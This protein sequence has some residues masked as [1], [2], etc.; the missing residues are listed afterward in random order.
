M[1]TTR[2]DGWLHL[3]GAASILPAELRAEVDLIVKEVD[4]C[5]DR[6]IALR[7]SHPLGLSSM[8]NLVAALAAADIGLEAA[9]TS[10]PRRP[11]PG[12][13]VSTE[14]MRSSVSIASGVA[15][16]WQPVLADVP[17]ALR[18]MPV[19]PAAAYLEKYDQAVADAVRDARKRA[20][21]HP[22]ARLLLNAVALAASC[23]LVVPESVAAR[24]PKPDADT[25]DSLSSALDHL[26][27]LVALSE[28][29]L[30]DEER[31]VLIH[32]G[33]LWGLRCT[34][35]ALG[36]DPGWLGTTL[37]ALLR[38]T[39]T[40]VGSERR[41]T[42]RLLAAIRRVHG[43][44]VLRHIRATEQAT[45]SWIA[46][47]EP[48]LRDAG[49]ADLDERLGWAALAREVSE[50]EA[51]LAMLETA[52]NATE[53]RLERALLHEQRGVLR[54]SPDE[55]VRARELL[56]SI[57]Q[58]QGLADPWFCLCY[59]RFLE[60]R[61]D[62]EAPRWYREITRTHHDNVFLMTAAAAAMLKEG[63]S[64]GAGA[65]VHR[66][67]QTHEGDP[68]AR[69]YLDHLRGELARRQLD[70]PTA[71]RAFRALLTQEEGHLPSLVS[72]GGLFLDIG[73]DAT[74]RYWLDRA[75][76]VDSENPQARLLSGMLLCRA[77]GGEEFAR[78]EVL[79]RDLI[80]ESPGQPEAH[81][82]LA[83]ALRRS[84]RTDEARR[85]LTDMLPSDR[86][87]PH[88]Q[89]ELAQVDLLEQNYDGAM[90]RLDR[91][92]RAGAGAVALAQQG[93][94]ACLRDGELR[95]DL[96]RVAVVAAATPISRIRIFNTWAECALHLN[97]ND[98]AAAAVTAAARIDRWNRFT[99]DLERQ[100]GLAARHQVS[101]QAFRETLLTFTEPPEEGGTP[102][103]RLES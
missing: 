43:R 14:I 57:R 47:L 80:Q 50:P 37:L 95:D 25:P 75:L 94:L 74:A 2:T 17:F 46:G 88:R 27:G 77:P 55:F 7:V 4:R 12:A 66:A 44:R 53:V 52:G 73:Y 70:H 96:F 68:Q 86:S 33:E 93:R 16:E 11:R 59:A 31:P 38:S 60:A 65:M 82:A 71:E 103:T 87:E 8:G 3:R 51:G 6:P 32:P 18:R 89:I 39:D 20:A 35:E 58:D 36:A 81:T 10:L 62:R 56:E 83:S 102:W 61:G 1:N 48:V 9:Q 101:P 92:R 19:G 90:D 91:A 100:L 85:V 45:P 72:L 41:H 21:Q 40:A 24:L 22:A 30:D 54:A 34:Q 67:E 84:G 63:D 23:D 76:A 26:H 99:S 97:R 79:L 29:L 13:L 15:S 49:D 69:A 28:E 5:N 98:Q 42:L 78:G 64:A